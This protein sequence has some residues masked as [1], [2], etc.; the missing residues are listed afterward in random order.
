LVW[1][2][3]DA[4]ALVFATGRTVVP[5]RTQPRKQLRQG[6]A[7]ETWRISYLRPCCPLPEVVLVQRGVGQMSEVAHEAHPHQ[8][9]APRLVCYLR[10]H[11]PGCRDHRPLVRDHYHYYAR[12]AERSTKIS[13]VNLNLDN[14]GI[15]YVHDL[16]EVA[17]GPDEHVLVLLDILDEHIVLG[18]APLAYLDHVSFHLHHAV[19]MWGLDDLT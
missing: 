11:D 3:R 17:L 8:V 19:T 13:S 1:P 18:L 5:V 7:I 2:A 12:S 6:R 4:E 14:K 9:V 16:V 15:T 10:G